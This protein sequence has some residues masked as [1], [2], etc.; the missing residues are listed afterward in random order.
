MQGSSLCP[1]RN[2]WYDPN[3]LSVA[4]SS[5]MLKHEIIQPVPTSCAHPFYIPAS[6]TYNFTVIITS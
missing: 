1:A 2:G 5:V 3:L 4:L 6:A